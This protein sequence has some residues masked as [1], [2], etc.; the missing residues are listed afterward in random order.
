MVH[1]PARCWPPARPAAC[2]TPP[3]RGLGGRGQHDW[4][5]V[6]LNVDERVEAAHH[7]MASDF[8]GPVSIGSE[9]RVTINELARITLSIAGK[10]LTIKHLNVGPPRTSASASSLK[11]SPR[12]SAGGASCASTPR[13]RTGARKL[14]DVSKLA[15]LG[16][17]ARIGLR[18]GIEATYRRLRPPRPGQGQESRSAS[19]GPKIP[20]RGQTP[21]TARARRERH[22]ELTE[23]TEPSRRATNVLGVAVSAVN[24]RSAVEDIREA[25]RDRKSGYVCVTGVHGVMESQRDPAL[26]SIHN[27]AQMVVPDGMPL[28]WLSKAAGHRQVDRVYGPDLMLEVC[29]QSV[30][31]GARH[32]F[33]GGNDGV[34]DMLAHRL[35]ERFPGL[36]V[37]G[38]F[39]PPF[40]PLSQGEDREIIDMINAQLPD[41][42]WVGLGTPKQERWM[43]EHLGRLTAP[44]ML[45]VGAA[46]DFHAGLKPQ[47]PR[48]MQRSG[49]EWLFRLVTEPRRLWRRYLR[50]NPAFVALVAAQK[51]GLRRY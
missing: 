1:Q 13:C 40:R 3:D 22:A 29:A 49:L 4:P 47:A 16:W 45:G 25:I 36:Q 6:P 20:R 23:L 7:L 28:V 33:Y 17:S 37:V 24:M 26:R 43:A 50:N 51:L 46:F 8:V 30:E 21:S 18:E 14:L 38:T 19:E 10:D 32:F 15:E 41:I 48:W 31:W 42:V 39:S 11:P 35:C 12:W 5:I 34:A 44:V 9:E 27:A 2:S